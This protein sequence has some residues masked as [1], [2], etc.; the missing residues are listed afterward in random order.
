MV[1]ASRRSN[2]DPEDELLAKLTET[3]ERQK[4]QIL[5]FPLGQISVVFTNLTQRW[6]KLAFL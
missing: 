5:I 3:V 2:T 6:E 1:N 4:S